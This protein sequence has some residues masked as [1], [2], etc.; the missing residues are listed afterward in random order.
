VQAMFPVQ[1]IRRIIHCHFPIGM[2]VGQIL[3]VSLFFT[4]P[5]SIQSYCTVTVMEL[6]EAVEQRLH[7]LKW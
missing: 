1:E 5:L 2:D 6:L 4:Y 7:S 3:N